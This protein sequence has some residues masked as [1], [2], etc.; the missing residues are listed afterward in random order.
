MSSAFRFPFVTPDSE[1]R[2][3][4]RVGAGVARTVDIAE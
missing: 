4:D 2:L 1:E 3:S